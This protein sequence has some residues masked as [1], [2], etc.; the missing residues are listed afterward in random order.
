[1]SFV[2]P[3]LCIP[4]PPARRSTAHRTASPHGSPICP[5]ILSQAARSGR[6]SIGAGILSPTATDA[7]SGSLDPNIPRYKSF[8]TEAM[9]KEAYA[10]RILIKPWTVNRLNIVAQIYAWGVD[11]IITDYPE[12]VR[13]WAVLKGLVVGPEYDETK[14][15]KCLRRYIQTV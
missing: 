9:V 2:Y 8:T 3:H 13:R 4:P 7:T 11:G 1:M 5:S 15:L 12:I 10:S 14:V 6:P